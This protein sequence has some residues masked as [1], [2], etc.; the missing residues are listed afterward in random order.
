ML[1]KEFSWDKR[2]W[3]MLTK[4]QLII[5]VASIPHTDTRGTVIAD[6][7]MLRAVAVP[8][9]D[10]TDTDVDSAIKAWVKA[11]IAE[12]VDYRFGEK[13][14]Q[15]VDFDRSNQCLDFVRKRSGKSG[16][17]GKI[18]Y[19]GKKGG[20][21]EGRREEGKKVLK[22]TTTDAGAPAPDKRLLGYQADTPLKKV[23]CGYKLAKGVAYDDRAWDKA[24]WSRHARSA[25]D[26]L[27]TFN[28]DWRGAVRC[29]EAIGHDFD[30]K[31]LSWVLSTIVKHAWEWRQK[32]E[33]PDRKVDAGG[34][35]GRVGTGAAASEGDIVEGDHV[36][37]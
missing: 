33:D 20:R 31:E 17:S 19:K 37:F 26:L 16:K 24:N 3:K 22:T 8:Q 34:G 35:T 10:Y 28:G 18:A 9:S 14:I 6:P 1:V 30:G 7:D 29:I 15:F 5:F 12:R 13:R 27:D 25:K 21:E 36:A 4:D 23:M 11:G 2:I 32:N